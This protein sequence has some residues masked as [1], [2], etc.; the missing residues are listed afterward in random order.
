MVF[1]K[2]TEVHFDLEWRSIYQDD[3]KGQK[4]YHDISM[5]DSTVLVQRGQS[6][7]KLP[8]KSVNSKRV[9]SL[10]QPKHVDVLR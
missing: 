6:F 3:K 2:Q 10:I 7:K 5:R 4:I 1:F 8:G 9:H